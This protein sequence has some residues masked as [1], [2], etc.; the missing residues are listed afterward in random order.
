[1]KEFIDIQ[2]LLTHIA[3]TMQTESSFLSS[4]PITTVEVISL[5]DKIADLRGINR[6]SN[7]LEFN[8]ICNN[9]NL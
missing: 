4:K 3:E 1:M 6:D 8:E 7:G 9:L 5:L 2:E